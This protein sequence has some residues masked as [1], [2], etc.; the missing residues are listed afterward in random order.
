MARNKKPRKKYRP[1]PIE[2]QFGTIEAVSTIQKSEQERIANYVKERID[3]VLVRKDYSYRAWFEMFTLVTNIFSSEKN[4]YVVGTLDSVSDILAMLLDWF[5]RATATEFSYQEVIP[6]WED[7]PPPG[8]FA[9]L[10]E[11][12]VTMY[13]QLLSVISAIRYHEGTNMTKR[14]TSTKYMYW[15]MA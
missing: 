13:R 6:F 4:G 2:S 9:K 3:D 14:W 5:Q 7:V 8:D 10:S 11:E 15:T 1:R 12:L